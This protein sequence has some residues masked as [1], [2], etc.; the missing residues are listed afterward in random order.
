LCGSST[1]VIDIQGAENSTKIITSFIN[2]TD[3]S[4]I[5]IDDEVNVAIIGTNEYKYGTLKGRVTAIDNGIITQET[6]NGNQSY[7]KID[8]ALND[9]KITS[10]DGDNIY[11]ENSMPVEARIIYK[12]ETYMEW[13]L[14]K[15]NLKMGN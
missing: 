7:Y 1:P 3:R 5:N 11:L 6:E 9:D 15:L 13:I 8:I 14:E 4:R 2:A 10:K 12:K